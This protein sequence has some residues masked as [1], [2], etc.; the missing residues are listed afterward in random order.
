MK[1][2]ALVLIGA[3]AFSISCKT[4]KT[5][6]TPDSAYQPA[7]ATDPG[8]KVFSVPE[9]NASRDAIKKEV[10]EAPIAIRK[11][12]VTFTMPEDTGNNYQNLQLNFSSMYVKSVG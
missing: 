4:I 8:T 12:T 5:A 9:I 10:E 7:V 11:E 6:K 1:K 2:L 3:L